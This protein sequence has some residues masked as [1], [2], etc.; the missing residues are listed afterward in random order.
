MGQHHQAEQGP[1]PAPTRQTLKQMTVAAKDVKK[2][3]RVYNSIAA[4]AKLHPAFYW[5]RVLRVQVVG[6]KT[7]IYTTV[8][9]DHRHSEEAVTVERVVNEAPS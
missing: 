4:A 1:T 8:Y 7:T 5:V 6:K 9:E 3:D 2:G